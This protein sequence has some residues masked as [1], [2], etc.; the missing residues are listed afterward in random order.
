MATRPGPPICHQNSRV[1]IKEPRRNVI[2]KYCARIIN[3]VHCIMSV[4]FTSLITLAQYLMITFPR[5]SFIYTREIWWQI[6]GPGLVAMAMAPILFWFLQWIG[7]I[8]V[9]SYQPERGR[10]E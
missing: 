5:C 10:L 3:E 9:Y 7:R 8:T 4:G 2:I 1:K 6:G